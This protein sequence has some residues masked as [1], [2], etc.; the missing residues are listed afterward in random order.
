VSHLNAFND[1]GELYCYTETHDYVFTTDGFLH[2]KPCRGE[3]LDGPISEHRFKK[4]VARPDGRFVV[5]LEDEHPNPVIYAYE[6]TTGKLFTL[7]TN[8]APGNPRHLDDS[9]GPFTRRD[10]HFHQG[11]RL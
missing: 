11:V 10:N 9:K 2:I 4:M 6:V 3:V 1:N 7:L 5:F 8:V